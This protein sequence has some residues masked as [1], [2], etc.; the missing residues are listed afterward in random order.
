M[1]TATGTA[2]MSA[3]TDVTSVP[4]ANAAMPNIGG[5]SLVNQFLKVRKFA[6]SARSAG[7]ALEIK[8]TAIATMITRTAM[9]AVEVIPRNPVSQLHRRLRGSAP[10]SPTGGAGGPG[11]RPG[12][13]PEAVVSGPKS[14]MVG[15]LVAWVDSPVRGGRADAERPTSAGPGNDG[16]PIRVS[17]PFTVDLCGNCRAD[18]HRLPRLPVTIRPFW[19]DQVSS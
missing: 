18:R 4:N 5:L 2:R 9:P 15:P 7:I 1:L 14:L 17:S 8:K 3:I 13:P 12:G 6:W 10:P 16:W 11:L 19:C